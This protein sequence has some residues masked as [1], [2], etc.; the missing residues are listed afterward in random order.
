MTST[1]RAPINSAI[2]AAIDPPIDPGR[3]IAGWW[4]TPMPLSRIAILRVIVYLYVPID[5]IGAGSGVRAHARLGRQLY[6]PLYISRLLHLPVP[7]AALV[8]TIEITVVVAALVAATGR[9]PR[10]SGGL[11]AALYLCWMLVAMSYGKVDHDRFAFLV[12]LA[13]LPTVGAARV[14]DRSRSAAAGW[15]LRCVHVAIV[16]TY[17]LS[18]WAKIRF[19]GWNWPTGATLERAL[20]R[21]KT[22][23][24]SWLLDKPEFLVPM[25]FAMIIGELS[26]PLVLLARSDRTRTLIA[27]TMWAFHIMVFAG[28]TILF[29][30]HC[31]A[32]ASL[33]PLEVWWASASRRSRRATRALFGRQRAGRGPA[34]EPVS[35]VSD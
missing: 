9:A 19:G 1:D 14:S 21:R 15:A 17:F 31:V 4:F 3:A 6:H 22:E 35:V 30:P 33:L 23:F 27:F 25:Q 5:V 11:A 8:T 26:S 20:I 32:I 10:L 28:L 16:L 2:K 18:A 24:S 34:R 12:A 29:V 7:T 13:V